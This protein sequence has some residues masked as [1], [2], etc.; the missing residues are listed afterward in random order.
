MNAE[1]VIQELIAVQM[2][3]FTPQEDAD[4]EKAWEEWHDEMM[5]EVWEDNII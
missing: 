3:P 5:E 4:E 2:R 1:K